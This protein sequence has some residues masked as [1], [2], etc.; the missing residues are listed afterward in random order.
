MGSEASQVQYYYWRQLTSPLESLDLNR[1]NLAAKTDL[2]PFRTTSIETKIMERTKVR[3][4]CEICGMRNKKAIDFHHIIP[5]TDPRCTNGISNLAIICSN[6]HRLVHAHEIIIEGV[7][8]T[9]QGHKLFW[10]KKGE[11][12][13]IRTGVILQDDGT[14]LILE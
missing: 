13:I 12:P 11:K 2:S 1:I 5:Q 7:F 14:A 6:C 3:T 10:H 9:S 8:Q 4:E